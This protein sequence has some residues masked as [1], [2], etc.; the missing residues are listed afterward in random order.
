[1][2]EA[3]HPR[4]L[5]LALGRMLELAVFSLEGTRGAPTERAA[6]GRVAPRIKPVVH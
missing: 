1:M 2:K 4:I 5:E 6:P 3:D